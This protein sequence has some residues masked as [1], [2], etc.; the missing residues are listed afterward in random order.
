MITADGPRKP[1]SADMTGS[2]Q[3]SVANCKPLPASGVQR[4]V[5]AILIAAALLSLAP[6]GSEAEACRPVD[7]TMVQGSR[8]VLGTYDEPSKPIVPSR[9]SF[10]VHLGSD[11]PQGMPRFSTLDGRP[12][13]VTKVTRI[14]DELWNLQRIELDIDQGGIVVRYPGNDTP[15]ATYSIDPSFTPRTRSVEVLPAGIT[16]W[17]DSDA[18][19][20]RVEG[21]VFLPEHFNNGRVH[22]VTGR[23]QRVVALYPNGTEEVIYD[24]VP[25][26]RLKPAEPPKIDRVERAPSSRSSR[27]APPLPA[28]LVILLLGLVALAPYTTPP[29]D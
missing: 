15:V 14:Q 2:P 24:D 17:I 18:V 26:D 9:P 13:R 11:G 8:N 16:L 4:V 5:R 23:K 28:V 19:A 25:T 7:L 29:A 22:V 1:A 6:S 10:F 21:Q 12:I 20:F 27:H 3:K